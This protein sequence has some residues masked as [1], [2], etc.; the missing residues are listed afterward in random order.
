MR[1]ARTHQ[2]AGA[3]VVDEHV[4]QGGDEQARD[5]DRDAVDRIEQPL[6][7][8]DRAG[9]HLGDR[10]AER[11]RAPGDAHRLVEEQDDAEGR[12]HLR[13]VVAVVEVAEHRDL[14]HEPDEERRRQGEE[15]RHE[16]A[17]RHR[18]EPR[19]EI[20]ADHVLHAVREVD[21]V[22]DAEDQRQPRRDQ[23]Q[24]DAELQ[25]V[26]RLHE[27]ERQRHGG[28]RE[29]LGVGGPPAEAGGPVR[30]RWLTRPSCTGRRSRRPASSKTFSTTCV[31]YL[32]SS[33][34]ATLTR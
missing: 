1:R 34:L 32:P 27:D 10:H 2:H 3:R 9:Q 22:H 24:E 25:A 29:I 11:R 15:Q 18:G 6:H 7:E 5:D 16:E 13:E 31:S 19:R 28:L 12:Q 26:E 8:H 30:R 21:E 23:E 17:A 33:R 4:E 14:E 20:G